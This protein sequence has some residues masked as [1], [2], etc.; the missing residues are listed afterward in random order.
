MR[1][2]NKLMYK[3]EYEKSKQEQDLLQNDIEFLDKI[4]DNFDPLAS[5]FIKQQGNNKR[6]K[7]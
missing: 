6:Q 4:E 7:F 1:D 2:K 5:L 3:K